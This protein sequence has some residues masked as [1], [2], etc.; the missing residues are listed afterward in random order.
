MKHR[1]MGSAKEAARTALHLA[2]KGNWEKLEKFSKKACRLFPDS[3]ELTAMYQ[4]ALRGLERYQEAAKVMVNYLCLRPENKQAYAHLHG[5]EFHFEKYDKEFIQQL[6]SLET[7]E[8]RVFQVRVLVWMRNGIEALMSF[9]HL[10]REYPDQEDLDPSAF[11]DLLYLAELYEIAEK[12]FWMAIE[13]DPTDASIVRRL[14]QTLVEQANAYSGERLR[15]AFVLAETLLGD[16]E[17]EPEAWLA[18]GLCYRAASRLEL[19]YPFF[20]KFFR[21][22]P[23]HMYRTVLTFD[24]GY[25]ETLAPESLLEIR[26]DWSLRL[27]RLIP[28]DPKVA[29]HTDFE[30]ERRLK[31]GYL[32]PDFGRHPVGYFA[33]SMIFHHDPERVEVF[34]YS[35]RDPVSMDDSVSQEFRQ[36]VGEDHWR[37]IGRTPAGELVQLIRSDRI[38]VLVDLAG[39]SKDNRIEAILNRSAPVQV[40]WLGFAWSTGAENMDYR[41]SDEITEPE[42]MCDALS[43]EEIWRLPR[44]FHAINMPEGLPEVAEPPCLKNGFITFGSFNNI[45]KL[46]SRTLAL[47]SRLLLAVPESRLILKHRSMEV[48][49]SREAIRSAFA[50]HGVDPGRVTFKGTTK[51]REEHFRYYGLMDIALDPLGYNGTT[52]TCEAL[53]MGVPVLTLPGRT[54]ASRVSAS[55]LHQVGL[56]GWIARD[57]EHFFRIARAAAAR[58]EAL[59]QRRASLRSA[60]LESPLSD[61]IGLARALEEAYRSMWRR[62]CG[63]AQPLQNVNPE[64]T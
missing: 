14:V 53:Y 63:A 39:H 57:E 21:K 12:A 55:L 11:G 37:W 51:H 22:F 4:A 56:D 28:C 34:M 9:D 18:M 17:N 60:F 38:D 62:A 2:K 6:S 8:G 36:H 47:W 49:D 30:P 13:R 52:T 32:S 23:D 50:A 1:K 29:L 5:L 61:G 48:F 24:S 42:G 43:S 26:R 54:H 31:I 59:A 41:I 7:L 40:H 16:Q 44:G 35:Q 64:E 20:E 15:E 45:N 46:G 58:P 25:V 33:K 3:F 27:K 19:A 10:C